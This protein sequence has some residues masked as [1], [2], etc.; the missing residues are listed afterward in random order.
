M[1]NNSALKC[2]LTKLRAE[3]K[4]QKDSHHNLENSYEKLIH[5]E[6]K[7]HEETRNLVRI[8]C[9]WR[10]SADKKMAEITQEVD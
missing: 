3:I 4:S 2:E 5:R 9:S 8:L 10:D 6:N 1:D 7:Q